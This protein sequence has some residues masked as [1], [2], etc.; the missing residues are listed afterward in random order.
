[1]YWTSERSRVRCYFA[2]ECR[3][4]LGSARAS[5]SGLKQLSY[6]A[7][8]GYTSISRRR[9]SRNV[10]YSRQALFFL[11]ASTHE[12][13]LP[14]RWR[15]PESKERISR[16]AAAGQRC[17]LRLATCLREADVDLNAPAAVFEA[18]RRYP[19][20]L[21]CSH[22][23]QRGSTTSRR[24]WN[25][26]E[27]HEN[28]EISRVLVDAALVRARSTRSEWGDT[29]GVRGSGMGTHAWR[30]QCCAEGDDS[31]SSIPRRP[32]RNGPG[33]GGAAGARRGFGRGRVSVRGSST[34]LKLC[35]RAAHLW[36]GEDTSEAMVWTW[37]RSWTTACRSQPPCL[38]AYTDVWESWILKVY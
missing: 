9:R 23:R 21:S 26:N 33:T 12:L 32:M 34:C 38:G 13:L 4:C 1:M 24:M 25:A 3:V 20:H 19:R 16:Y 14:L 29:G 11:A 18:A 27:G 8:S 7:T 31:A 22:A 2:A 17:A 28:T 36:V 6:E 5:F 30:M 15:R 10:L 35:V 37:P